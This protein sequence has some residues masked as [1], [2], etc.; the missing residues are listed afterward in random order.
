MLGIH[1][2]TSFVAAVVAFQ[3]VPGPGTLV[4]LN[5]TA[6]HGVRSGMGAVF[7][8]LAGDLLFM[9]SAVFGLAAVLMARPLI[10]SSLQW[11]GIAYLSWLGLKLLWSPVT[12]PA[13]EATR[14]QDTWTDF[15][16]AFAVCLTNPK[17]IIFFMAFFPLFL[18]TDSPPHTLGLM[19]G[20]VS[21]ISLACAGRQCGR[22]E[23]RPLA[24]RS[25]FGQ[26]P[27]RVGAGWLRD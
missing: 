8:T 4:I 22:G 18:T 21:L 20:H 10:L 25:P 24:A 17:A 15:R 13:A 3:L 5:A 19:I 1:N 11:V 14:G 7:G 12:E 16:R 23:V 9:L 6:R 2:Y 27:A 26:A